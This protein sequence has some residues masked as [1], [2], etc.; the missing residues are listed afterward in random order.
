MT[1]AEPTGDFDRVMAA[2]HS[3]LEQLRTTYDVATEG[4]VAS[5]LLEL[6]LAAEQLR[7]SHDGLTARTAELEQRH[8]AADRDR[9]LMRSV[10]RDFPKACL[11]LDR[12]G[13]VRR[14]NQ[15]ATELLGVSSDYLSGKALVV[16][17][18]VAERTTF[19]ARFGV[20]LR[21]QEEQSFGTVL[22]RRG[23]AVPTRLQLSPVRVPNDPRPLIAVVAEPLHPQAGAEQSTAGSDDVPALPTPSEP[24]AEHQV[25][26][27]DSDVIR[28][29]TRRGDLISDLTRVLL[30][31]TGASEPVLVQRAGSLL[32]TD[33]ADWAVIDLIRDGVP[34]RAVVC[35]SAA[36]EDALLAQVIERADVSAAPLPCA[37]MNGE[38]AQL[39]PH[40]E[41]TTLLGSDDRSLPLLSALGA[42]TLLCVPV[43][44]GG[45]PIGAITL[46][47]TRSCESFGLLEQAALE[48]VGDLLGRSLRRTPRWPRAGRGSVVAAPFLPHRLVSAPEI[49]VAWLHRP[50]WQPGTGAAPFLDFYDLPDGWGAALG[51]VADSGPR[52]Q[53]YV[54]MI[55]QWALLAASP[56]TY[57]SDVLRQ[58]D[59]GLRRLHSGD[60]TV[61]AA[62]LLLSPQPDGLHVRLA[63]AGHRSSMTVRADGR[64][65]RTDGGG[66]PLNGPGGPITHEDV[67]LLSRG[68]ALVLFTNELPEVTN[69]RGET[70]AASGVLANTLARTSG[71][72]TQQ[73]MDA[74]NDELSAFAPHGLDVDVVVV[75]IRFLGSTT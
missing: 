16:F 34:T 75:G 27:P 61:S 50:A 19:R 30:D 26:G 39:H 4:S 6:E 53:A 31:E 47:R 25:T 23:V 33:T 21:R 64:V 58:L 65:Q 60:Q 2:F 46:L 52:S 72:P 12:D 7:Q 41:D 70:F 24:V 69:E 22:L 59:E 54:A 28:S 32:C 36:E 44:A 71:Q 42:H 45:E 63:S 38:G 74:L 68:D 5:A 40:V 48:G 35:A 9:H 37:V 17:V 57:P 11:L 49:D 62:V 14:V 73:I 43:V 20:V 1:E 51:S 55:R 18:E 8:A 29:L 3:R 10:F 66:L 13:R 56:G 15:R 67:D